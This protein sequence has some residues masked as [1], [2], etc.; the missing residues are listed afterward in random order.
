MSNNFQR[1]W[2]ATNNAADAHKPNQ[3]NMNAP[4]NCQTPDGTP[5]MKLPGFGNG[6]MCFNPYNGKFEPPNWRRNI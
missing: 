3:P 2:A 5:T 4:I 1:N 6:G